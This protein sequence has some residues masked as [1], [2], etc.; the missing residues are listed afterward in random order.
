MD[1]VNIYGPGAPRAERYGGNELF[2][3]FFSSQ[4]LTIRPGWFG[5]MGTT[6]GL[7][8]GVALLLLPYAALFFHDISV[9]MSQTR[10]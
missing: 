7:F 6:V 5:A 3:L 1:F 8:C 10:A 9:D 4:S 2:L